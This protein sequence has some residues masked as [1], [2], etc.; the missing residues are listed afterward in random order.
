M[1]RAT[2]LA[3]ILGLTVSAW[4]IAWVGAGQ[5]AGAVLVAGVHGILAI[6]LFNVVP[7]A[8]CGIAW[9][10]L[11][12]PAPPRG[13]LLMTWVRFLRSSVSELVPIGG[14]LVGIRVMILNGID[15]RT[16]GATIVVDMTLELVS[17]IAFTAL[18][19][20]LLLLDGRDDALAAWS[21]VG[22]G[23][24]VATAV[25]FLVVQQRGF[26]RWLEALPHRIAAGMSWARLPELAGIDGEIHAIYRR[27]RALL[28]GTLWHSVGWIVG[29]GEAWL[30]LW[31]LDAPVSFAEVLIIES[32][33]FALR[34]AAFVVPGALG[35][36]EG[37][38]IA[39]GAL[40][41][42]GPDV[43]LALSLLKRA[44][45][46][47]LAVPAL[48]AWKLL[49]LRAWRRRAVAAPYAS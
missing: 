47:L 7:I 41:G 8:L 20:M 13:N 14:E 46:V 39:L 35:V 2:F 18:G 11:I 40:F 22:L 4:L 23:V 45:E 49:E 37:G 43:A 25:A 26:F 6:T 34:S 31:F 32:L 21:L 9:C 30:A 19:L 42:L 3:L 29:V 1:R 12:E 28:M 36:Q 24:A 5:V 27:P 17:Q 10:A 33:A 16:A 38:Y 48:L 44:R 15:S